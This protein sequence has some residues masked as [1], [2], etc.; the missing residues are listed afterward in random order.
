MAATVDLPRRFTVGPTTSYAE[1][2]AALAVVIGLVSVSRYVL[3]AVRGTARLLWPLYGFAVWAILSMVWF[4]PS[5]DGIQNTLVYVA[6]AALVP[7]TAATVIR[8]D[9]SVETARRAITC[10]ILFAS[11]LEACNLVH[12][13]R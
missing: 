11:S 1:V 12:R 5:F 6:F 9:L 3:G 2:T 4:R 13:R 10:A 8:G 7:V